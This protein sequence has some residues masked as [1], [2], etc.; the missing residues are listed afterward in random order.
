VRDVGR[1][2]AALVP[3][4]ANDAVEAPALS[5]DGRTLAFVTDASDVRRRAG[6][7]AFEDDQSDPQA[8]AV[9]LPRRR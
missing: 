6:V 3:R 2:A 9:R 8:Y 1:R 7:R 4:R 5:S